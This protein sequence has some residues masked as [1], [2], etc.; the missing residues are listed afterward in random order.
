MTRSLTLLQDPLEAHRRRGAPFTFN[1]HS[2]LSFLSLLS[3]SP[4]SVPIPYPTFSHTIG[5]PVSG[6]VVTSEHRIVLLEG[7]YNLLDDPGWKTVR[8]SC[9]ATVW[10]QVE[11]QVARERLIERH[12]LTGVCSTLDEAKERGASRLRV[13]LTHVR[14][15]WTARTG[16]T[17]ST[18]SHIL[19]QRILSSTACRIPDSLQR[20]RFGEGRGS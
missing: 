6:T 13:D 20:R 16:S 8:K 3:S 17:Q 2:Y 15:Q 9:T 14:E 12:V 10:V 11:W 4:L 19:R 5:D 1:L 18:S 7:L